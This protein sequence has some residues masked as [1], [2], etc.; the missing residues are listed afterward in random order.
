MLD[1]ATHKL[2][3]RAELPDKISGNSIQVTQG[4]NPKIVISEGSIYEE[5]GRGGILVLDGVTLKKDREI[6]HAGGGN[7]FI[8][9]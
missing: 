7:L 4:D 5:H 6:E 9:S 2:I 8:K 3:R 1:G